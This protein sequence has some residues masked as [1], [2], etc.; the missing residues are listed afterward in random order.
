MKKIVCI[1]AVVLMIAS[2]VYAQKKMAI[3]AKDLPGMKGMWTGNISFGIQ[4]GAGSAC[5]LEIMNDTIPVKAKLTVAQVPDSLASSLGLMAGKNEMESDNGKI[6]SQGTIVWEGSAGGFFEIV[7]KGD[8]KV[9]A[10]YWFKGL[11]GDATLTKK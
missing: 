6:T 10:S 11:R 4:A 7:K 8:K 9:E 1:I 5:T 3:T 2:V